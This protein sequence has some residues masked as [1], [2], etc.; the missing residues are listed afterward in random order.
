[1]KVVHVRGKRG[2][3]VPVLF[4]HDEEVALESIIKYRLQ[5]GVDEANVYVFGAPTKGSKRPLRGNDCMRKLLEQ[6]PDLENPERIGSTELHKYCATVSQ[7]V[8]LSET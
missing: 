4:S 3:Q 5:V 7:I 6:I 2:Q 1:M 8:D